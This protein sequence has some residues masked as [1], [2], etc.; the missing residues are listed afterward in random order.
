MHPGS[1]HL[2]RFGHSMF[3]NKSIHK[4]YIWDTCSRNGTPCKICRRIPQK[5]FSLTPLNPLFN[6]PFGPGLVLF[7]HSW[8]LGRILHKKLVERCAKSCLNSGVFW[9]KIE[10]VKKWPKIDDFLYIKRFLLSFAQFYYVF[11]ET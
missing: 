2:Y 8:V 5:H 11:L 3:W 6:S 4:I 10:G 7:F 1:F 9:S